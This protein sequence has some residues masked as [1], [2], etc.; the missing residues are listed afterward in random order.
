MDESARKYTLPILS[1]EQ[2]TTWGQ[3]T[4]GIFKTFETARSLLDGGLRKIEI[5][6]P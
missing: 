4:I 3:Q 1:E 6:Y 2:I 5:D